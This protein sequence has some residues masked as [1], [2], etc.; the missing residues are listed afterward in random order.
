MEVCASC[1]HRNQTEMQ[2][3]ISHIYYCIT[4]HLESVYIYIYIYIRTFLP[5]EGT[6]Q[7]HS[8]KFKPCRIICKCTGLSQGKHLQAVQKHRKLSSSHALSKHLDPC[9]PTSFVVYHDA[10]GFFVS[11]KYAKEMWISNETRRRGPDPSFSPLTH[12]PLSISSPSTASSA[13]LATCM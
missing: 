1:I 9:L 11:R 2:Q 7:K 10:S 13:P 4:C 12:C 5:H 3:E 8:H 6:P